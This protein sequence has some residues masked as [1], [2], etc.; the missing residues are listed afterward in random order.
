MKIFC[1]FFCFFGQTLQHESDPFI[2]ALVH[3]ALELIPKRVLEM[4]HDKE[5]QDRCYETL[6]N[7]DFQIKNH[8]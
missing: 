8:K 3:K 7:Y 4:D 6:A 5:F 1:L 2:G